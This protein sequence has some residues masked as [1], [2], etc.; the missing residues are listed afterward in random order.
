MT[1]N[2]KTIIANQTTTEN[3]GMAVNSLISSSRHS[4]QN[5]EMTFM[6][7]DDLKSKL[8]SDEW[9]IVQHV[10]DRKGKLRASFNPSL[11]PQRRITGMVTVREYDYAND[12]INESIKSVNE[13]DYDIEKGKAK[14]VWRMLAF[15]MSARPEHQMI[16]VTQDMYMADFSADGKTKFA[17]HEKR[18]M[19]KELDVLVDKVMDIY[20][21][22]NARDYAN[23][24]DKDIDRMLSGQGSINDLF[25]KVNVSE[26]MR[27]GFNQYVE[28]NR[29]S[30]KSYLVKR[31]VLS[32]QH[33]VMRWG[34]A[35][36]R[37]GTPRI[38]DGRG[39][40][41]SVSQGIIDESGSIIN[42]DEDVSTSRYVLDV[43]LRNW[44]E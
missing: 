14:Y 21:E 41:S 9:E 2:S 11:I 38:S 10:I 34:E 8:T 24:I 17:F 13:M 7:I 6:P 18:E 32:D 39:V 12:K 20:G 1:C 28:S 26:K 5:A 33:G 25:T 16:P 35:M 31:K 3:G 37:I 29:E 40:I 22:H 36:G 30:I 42:R 19:T 23:Q 4:S 44:K 27:Q 15:W 43:F